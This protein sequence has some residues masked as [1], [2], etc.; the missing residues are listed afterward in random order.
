MRPRIVG[1]Q[2]GIDC[3]A[4]AKAVAEPIASDQAGVGPVDRLL[5]ATSQR[6]TLRVE[7]AANGRLSK[8]LVVV[9]APNP[10][11]HAQTGIASQLTDRRRCRSEQTKPSRVPPSRRWYC[12]FCYPIEHHALER[13]PGGFY[14]RDLAALA[15]FRPRMGTGAASRLL[16]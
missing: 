12:L 11:P 16:R 14:A 6:K 1:Q 3:D 4:A 7:S 5:M 2:A 8:H 10:W 9:A 13:T 15:I